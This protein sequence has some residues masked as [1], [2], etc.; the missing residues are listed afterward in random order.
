[1]LIVIDQPCFNPSLFQWSFKQQ[2][3]HTSNRYHN[4]L[5][6]GKQALNDSTIRPALN[7]H[8]NESVFFLFFLGSSIPVWRWIRF[9]N[10]SHI[11][12][13][14]TQKVGGVFLEMDSAKPCSCPAVFFCGDRFVSWYSFQT[15]NSSPAVWNGTIWG[16]NWYRFNHLFV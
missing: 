7:N 13:F 5:F 8:Q 10:F 9:L 4:V 3:Q 14:L 16:K 2:Q 11:N 6:K 12:K 15:W 1:M